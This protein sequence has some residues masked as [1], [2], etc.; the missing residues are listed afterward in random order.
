[1]LWVF[2]NLCGSKE[3][4]QRH[5][6]EGFRSTCGSASFINNT[7]SPAASPNGLLTDLL[8]GVICDCRVS[9]STFRT[10]KYCQ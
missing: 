9:E 10:L 5:W 3:L 4:S 2:K 6:D 8:Y 7:E 1:M